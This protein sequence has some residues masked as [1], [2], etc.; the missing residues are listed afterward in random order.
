M[1]RVASSSAGTDEEVDAKFNEF[2]A[3]ISPE[4]FDKR[5]SKERNIRSRISSGIFALATVDKV[6]NK[7]HLSRLLDHGR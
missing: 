4:D 7:N 5:G 1:Q 6:V 3:P 2:K